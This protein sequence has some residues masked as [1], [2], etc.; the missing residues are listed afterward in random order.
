MSFVLMV[1][2][3]DALKEYILPSINDSNY[4]LILN[5]HLFN[6][7]KD[8]EVWLEV[9]G[10]KW[11]FL[12]NEDYF[13]TDK[14][15]YACEGKSIKNGNYYNILDSHKNSA[16]VVAIETSTSFQSM[17][18][19]DLS[20]IKEIFI[21]TDP[22]NQI[23]YD[24][25]NYVSRN[26]AALGKSGDIWT[27]YDSSSNGTFLNN[28]RINGPVTLQFGDCINIFGLKIVFL[29]SVLAVSK[30]FG[31]WNV[32][33]K[34]LPSYYIN[35][36]IL[37]EEKRKRKEKRYY[38]RSPRLF[39]EVYT[40]EV[41]IEAPPALNKQRNKPAFMVIG[42]AFTMAIPMLLGTGMS[43]LAS[44]MMGSTGSL[45]MATGIITALG[46]AVLGVFW[47]K[48]NLKYEKET[49]DE[50]EVNRYN[51]YGQ[52]LIEVAD[53]LKK[54]Y[55]NNQRV[56]NAMYLCGEDCIRANARTSNLWN[57]NSTH[58]DFL[59]VRLGLGDIPFQ[60]AI[61]IPKKKFMMNPDDLVKKPEELKAN[62]STLYNVPVTIDLMKH[63]MFGLVGG[64]GKAGAYQVMMN[65]IEQIAVNNCYTD[66]KLV[67]IY[68]SKTE[69][70]EKRW[71]FA[72]WL[73]HVWSE[74]KR[75][76]FIA[77]NKET[78]GDV[79][80]ELAKI[81]R[82]RAE[83]EEHK[84]KTMVLPH[85][86][87]IV[88]NMEL[89]EGE[90]IAK[91]IMQPQK[92]YGITTLLLT[93]YYEELP[94]EC[95]EII[96]N[97]GRKSVIFNVNENSDTIQNFAPDQ[98]HMESLEKLARELSGIEVAEVSNGG[99]IP[100]SLDFFEM[101]GVNGLKDLNVLERWTKHR[102]YDS[103]RAL[104]GK[105][106]GNA[107]CYL[108]IHEKYHGPHGL[109]AG[110]TGSGK[111]ETLQTYMLSLAVEFSPY[112][113]AFFVI[114]YKG[115][116]MANLFSGLPHLIGQISNLSGNQVQRAMI[117]I[118][119]ENRRRQRIFSE[120]SVNNINLYTRLFKNG[121]ATEPIP[122]L[123]IIIDEF[124]EL[125]RE[126][127]EF[128]KEL[129]SVA[130][131][132]RS[133]GVHLILAT[134][135]P[136]GTVDDNIWSNTKFR[137]C[138]RVADRQ[139]S[140][141]MLHKP[142][143]AY[144]TQAGRCYLQVGSDEV[145]ELFQSGY[146]GAVYD[147]DENASKTSIAQ[148][149]SLTGKT[150]AVGSRIKKE[151][152]EEAK[153]KW[154]ESLYNAFS[155]ALRK[156]EYTP[157]AVLDQLADMTVLTSTMYG[158]IKSQGNEFEDNEYN[159][160]RLVDFMNLCAKIMANGVMD[161]DVLCAQAEKDKIKLPELKEKTQLDAVVEYLAKMAEENHYKKVQQLWLPVLARNIYLQ[162]IAGYD[163]ILLEDANAMHNTG[164]W[165]LETVIGMYDDPENQAQLPL[166]IDFA[167]AGHLAVLGTVV[168]GKSTFLQTLIYAMITQYSPQELN[169]Y[170]IDYS[171]HMLSAFERAPHVGGVMYDSDEE[172]ISKFFNL[173]T[174]IMD[175]R[176]DLL[177]GGNYAQY[178][179]VNGIVIP[180]IFVVIDNLANFRE[181]TG[182][183]YE[184]IIN[185]ISREGVGY[186]IYL[187]VSAAGWGM[188]EIP[189]RIGDN[190]KT[191]I[192][193]DMGD[194]F[195]MAEAL[196]VGRIDVMPEADVKG[197]GLAFT[198]GR[199]LEFQTAL[200]LQAS[201]D[202][203]RI[204]E[205]GK[206]CEEMSEKWQG[207]RARP[208]P[209]IPE[210][211]VLG[212]LMQL[213]DYKTA[214]ETRKYLPIAYNMEDASIYSIDL[215][216][217]YCYAIAG[218]ARTGIT[219]VLKAAMIA[220][221]QKENAEIHVIETEGTELQK[222]T[223]ELAS[224]YG[225]TSVEYLQ[226]QQ[227]IFDFFAGTVPE[228]KRRNQ[229]K[230]KLIAGYMEPDEI[231]EAISDQKQIFIFLAD[232]IS[233]VNLAYKPLENGTTMYAYI[234]NIMA[235]GSLHNF[236][237]IGCINQDRA[238]EAVGMAIY[239]SF[240]GYKAGVY[241]GGNL[242]AQKIFTFENLTY[243]ES[244]K[245]MKKGLGMT[246][247]YENNLEGKTIVLPLVKGV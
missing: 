226:T 164:R 151:K 124:A 41:E 60:V 203:E 33:I 24:L 2:S 83:R 94:N 20:G 56:L 229:I 125:K 108:D 231:Y 104:V 55:E 10:N 160:A 99:E 200:A 146:S 48:A 224:H 38:K 197:R 3:K 121:E 65:I 168:S 153:R 82:E 40:D 140:N 1:Q 123:F 88:D 174:R 214:I 86:I 100:N 64:E 165:T 115:G 128:M 37:P 85:Y 206:I 87:I 220:A 218:R 9:V 59:T 232:A 138:L 169:V 182:E 35:N 110:T 242:D 97:D 77:N 198:E 216:K 106:G 72:R 244:T 235:K 107:D 126:E 101:Y 36:S 45:F 139:D 6:F 177:K 149:L 118:K 127:P 28:K 191:V 62:Y 92:E 167:E 246:P 166:K 247:S 162:N 43:M 161:I 122:H 225:N 57:R 68:T 183:T 241:L 207:R 81:M 13:V 114:D 152:K 144:I 222:F 91:Y 155:I 19:L 95:E 32:N 89:L 213:E 240:T 49:A 190:I 156:L 47:A 116:G 119:S 111:S 76:R 178:V 180:A 11:S 233:F 159:R 199:L 157:A 132:G 201:D 52:Y 21:G 185:R 53:T 130:Q 219:N 71:E 98:A 136:S 102:T 196:R 96:Q 143:A 112:D 179:K 245:S 70:E 22:A 204:T 210:K 113:V 147:P 105:K 131:V 39:E 145:Y 175:E 176:K 134:Q 44:R 5:K 29:G 234:E 25:F 15:G 120:H 51:S 172:K 50:N 8:I 163:P 80:F 208:I 135:K 7:T 93:E 14:N 61:T 243:S 228:F 103:M 73:P 171:S 217:D 184:D 30:N 78:M 141:D 148:M 187:I 26:H 150:A 46:S 236:H 221:A 79:G 129:I 137:L 4:T 194:K 133:L 239:T 27:L 58:G 18:K 17:N 188:N 181:K 192:S 66:V 230:Q 42:P 154:L 16:S 202:F 205:I 67:F 189:N 186:G 170:A 69:E 74:D 193:L 63:T 75:C 227:Q 90:L 117:S 212:D 142:D 31:E 215:S 223:E 23:Q 195:K 237:F 209:V 109:V 158:I 34:G 173:I 54:K 211:P 12:A 84:E 238:M